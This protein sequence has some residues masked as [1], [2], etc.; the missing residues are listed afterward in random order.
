MNKPW[1]WF[2]FKGTFK[3]ISFQP[4]CHRQGQFPLELRRCMEGPGIFLLLTEE[5]LQFLMTDTKKM[6]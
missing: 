4:H 6:S 5:K 3:I 2:G 1:E